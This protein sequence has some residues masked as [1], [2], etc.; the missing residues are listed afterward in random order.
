MEAC[1]SGCRIRLCR[2]IVMKKAVFLSILIHALFFALAVCLLPEPVKKDVYRVLKITL[3]QVVEQESVNTAVPESRKPLQDTDVPEVI[4]EMVD[5]EIIISEQDNTPVIQKETVPSVKKDPVQ[6]D[7]VEE[8]TPFPENIPNG[9]A[10]LEAGSDIISE[11]NPAALPSG[12]DNM[13]DVKQSGVI[14]QDHK[15]K[16]SLNISWAD[17]KNRA[18]L[19][20]DSPQVDISG[21]SLLM[22]T[23]RINFIVQHDGTVSHVKIVPPGSNSFQVDRKL[24]E[25]VNLLLFERLGEND[26]AAEGVITINLKVREFSLP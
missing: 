19:N 4:P 15:D 23:V 11:R 12:Q 10:P 8:D 3:E 20:G 24:R 14:T 6:Q 1:H 13:V 7:P 5:P 26:P 22:D 18:L 2:L 16:N 9:T 25:W 21:N 17:G